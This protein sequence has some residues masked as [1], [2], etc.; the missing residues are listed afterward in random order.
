MPRALAQLSAKHARV[1][2]NGKGIA[3]GDATN[4]VNGGG[5]QQNGS[6]EQQQGGAA[7]GLHGSGSGWSL[8]DGQGGPLAGTPEAGGRKGAPDP[9][10]AADVP[11]EATRA[12]QGALPPAPSPLRAAVLG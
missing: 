2:A 11:S 8:V 4:A 7:G 10:T 6:A 3:V 9:N 5:S 1:Q 12:G